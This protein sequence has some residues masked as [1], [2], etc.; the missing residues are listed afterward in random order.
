MSAGNY[1]MESIDSYMAIL[2]NACSKGVHQS[3]IERRLI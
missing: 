3:P 1:Y 2:W